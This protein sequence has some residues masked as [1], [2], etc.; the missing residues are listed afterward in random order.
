MT[1]SGSP[2]QS[3]APKLMA[4][5]RSTTASRACTMCS[6]QTIEMPSARSC[7]MVPMSSSTSA[8]V[9]PP[10]ISSS[11]R[12][13][14]SPASALASSRRLRLSS[15]RAARLQVGLVG[16]AGELQRLDAALVA[17]ALAHAAT[18]RGADQ[19]VLEDAHV[20]ERLGDLVRAAEPLAAAVLPRLMG[21]VAL[22]EEDP[23]LVGPID[24]GDE[25][26]QRSLAGAVRPDDAQRFAF[27]QRDAEVVDDL[28]TA[29]GLLEAAGFKHH[30]HDVSPPCI[31]VTSWYARAEAGQRVESFTSALRRN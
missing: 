17:G 23:T 7:L 19:D 18:V 28:H 10:A 6:I 20:L 12:T 16:E 8:S 15:V 22:L 24:A 26:E 27:V 2:W 9:S 4:Q 25:I 1:S 29:E 30:G 5:M 13:V 31:K 14:G 3:M 11:R 21:D